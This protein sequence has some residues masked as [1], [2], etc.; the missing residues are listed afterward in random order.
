MCRKKVIAFS[1]NRK[2]NRYSGLETFANS[3]PRSHQLLNK[4]T[5][6]RMT[7]QESMRDYLM[8][9]EELNLTNVEETVSDQMLCSVVLKDFSKIF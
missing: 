1:K 8:R 4:L 9:T 6:I 7:S 3:S 2:T 5:N